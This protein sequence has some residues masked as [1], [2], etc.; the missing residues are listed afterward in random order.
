VDEDRK[1]ARLEEKRASRFLD[2]LARDPFVCI[3]VTN[4]GQV[5]IV[6]SQI[7]EEHLL[8]IKKVLKEIEDDNAL[9]D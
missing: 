5:Q 8:R 6:S 9:Q 2:A 7:S 1:I 4:D 3:I